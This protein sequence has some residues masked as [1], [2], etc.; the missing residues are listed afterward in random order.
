MTTKNT[1]HYWLNLECTGRGGNDNCRKGYRDGRP[2]H[3]VPKWDRETPTVIL[4]TYHYADEGLAVEALINATLHAPTV[5]TDE[6]LY[7]YRL[8]RIAHK[9]PV[10]WVDPSRRK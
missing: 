9:L 8:Q 1:T 3:I 2:V 6:E 7:A 5:T 4:P 10:G